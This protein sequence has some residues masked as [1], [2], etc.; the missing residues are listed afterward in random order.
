MRPILQVFLCFDRSAQRDSSARQPFPWTGMVKP[1]YK[2]RFT[3]V[4]L[5]F[6]GYRDKGRDGTSREYLWPCV[7][8]PLSWVNVHIFTGE[9]TFS[10]NHSG[11]YPVPFRALPAQG[12]KLYSSPAESCVQVS[13]ESL[14]TVLIYHSHLRSLW[15]ESIGFGGHVGL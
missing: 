8:F 11:P 10:S 13:A 4:H 2:S 12:P 15:G 7:I 9:H 1:K 14:I 5:I 3:N 6:C